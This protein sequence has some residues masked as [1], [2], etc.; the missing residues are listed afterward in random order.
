METKKAP[1]RRGKSISKPIVPQTAT[2]LHDVMGDAHNRACEAV[3]ALVVDALVF[4]S[5]QSLDI[6][7]SDA[8]P[9][10]DERL[11]NAVKTIREGAR[12]PM[13]MPEDVRASITNDVI[14]ARQ[15]RDH[16][17]YRAAIRQY[18]TERRRYDLSAE[19]GH[20][21]RTRD[22]IAREAALSDLLALEHEGLG[23]VLESIKAS[24]LLAHPP[25]P[26]HI[27]IHNLLIR[28][29]VMC[30]TGASKA[31]KSC[32]LMQM[33]LAMA[34]GGKLFGRFDCEPSTVVIVDLESTRHILY[35]KMKAALDFGQFKGWLPRDTAFLDRL[36]ILTLPD[37]T[38]AT[39]KNIKAFARRD[40]RRN[41]AADAFIVDPIY[42]MNAQD[43]SRD[44]N[45][46]GDITRLLTGLRGAAYELGA[47][48]IYSHHH[49]KGAQGGRDF[50][51]RASGSGVH[52]R[53]AFCL[54]SFT[55][56]ENDGGV[57]FEAITR[58]WKTP[59]PLPLRFTWP[60]FEVDTSLPTRVKGS[61]GRPPS[62]GT[63]PDELTTIIQTHGN[64]NG[65]G[66]MAL[67]LKDLAGVLTISERTARRRCEDAGLEINCGFVLAPEA[68]PT[69][70]DEDSEDEIP[71]D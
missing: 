9:M 51:D 19:L 40:C 69:L 23:N 52:A 54:A 62:A 12:A 71:F 58:G 36:R 59:E 67:H 18:L 17:P 38:D 7:T 48:L 3:W 68:K 56:L 63:N 16:E 61:P 11:D 33:A 20:A 2:T 10:E 8:P 25:E 34:A 31:G 47:S 64:Y 39:T 6:L 29:G 14:A 32:A 15:I 4:Q 1:G 26:D 5:S 66:F 49:A 46:A 41:G 22:A 44:E 57:L 70:T 28:G 60:C 50:W 30:L 65:K 43:P 21:L 13:D 53:F 42:L 27:L 35:I 37:I 24:D 55:A 45:D